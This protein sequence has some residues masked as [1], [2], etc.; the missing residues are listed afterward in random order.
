MK[1]VECYIKGKESNAQ[2]RSRDTKEKGHDSKD[3]RTQIAISGVGVK[4]MLALNNRHGPN[5][6]TS[7]DIRSTHKCL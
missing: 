3:A 5:K 7:E 2:K 6:M 1:R 4:G